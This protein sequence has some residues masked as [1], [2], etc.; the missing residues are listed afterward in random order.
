MEERKFECEKKVYIERVVAR[1]TCQEKK[2]VEVRGR[3]VERTLG[4]DGMLIHLLSTCI[5]YS[6]AFVL[7]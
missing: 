2:K 4:S 3:I 6:F 7:L 5:Y 1:C